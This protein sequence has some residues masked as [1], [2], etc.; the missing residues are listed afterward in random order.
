M[1]FEFRTRRMKILTVLLLF[2]LTHVGLIM[3]QQTPQQAR[4]V[5]VSSPSVESQESD[6]QNRRQH[7]RH[8]KRNPQHMEKCCVRKSEAKPRRRD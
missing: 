8:V 2:L 1:T 6:P 7:L 4:P 3:A 5:T